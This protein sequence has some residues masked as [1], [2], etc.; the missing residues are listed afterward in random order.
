MLNSLFIRGKRFFC[1]ATLFLILIVC[2]ATAGARDYV[3]PGRGEI[4]DLYALA[5]LSGG[6]V[7]YY[8]AYFQLNG[9]LTISA[10]DT[11][12]FA[13]GQLLFVADD[14]TSTGYAI[15]IAGRLL[16][17]GYPHAYCMLTSHTDR[18]GRWYGIQILPT[19][20]GSDM[21]Y[22][23]LSNAVAGISCYGASPIIDHCVIS[24]CKYAGIYC[25]GAAE[26]FISDTRILAIHSGAGIV[27]SRFSRATLSNNTITDNQAGVVLADPAAAASVA[28]NR[29][30]Y[31]TEIG[32]YAAGYDTSSIRNNQ[33]EW[34][35][36]G[37]VIA[38]HSTSTLDGNTV[39][40]NTLLGI[41]TAANASPILRKNMISNNSTT[42]GGFVAFDASRPDLGF[43]EYPGGNT[44]RDNLEYDLVNFT[45]NNLL[46]FG[47]SWTIP[48]DIDSVIYDD[49]EDIDDADGSGFISG[50][51]QYAPTA[52]ESCWQLYY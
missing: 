7:Q 25:Y 1:G 33:I 3:T 38:S 52:S 8:G 45:T 28:Y 35:N 21:T 48:Q 13:G 16:A 2:A 9:N 4:F 40:S 49:E 23:A 42:I 44:F 41:A 10:G 5:A 22:C 50:V 43:V 12:Y 11:L 6:T 14:P 34:N 17:Y 36:A 51:V 26:P 46:A 29:I 19:S 24:Q 37:I 39:S 20:T 47:N 18:A 31:N 27:L 15:K 30:A 32:L